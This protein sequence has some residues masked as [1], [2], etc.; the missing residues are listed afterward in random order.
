MSN[1][2]NSLPAALLLL[3][4]GLTAGA[5][6]TT[7]TSTV[8]VLYGC[9][10]PKN[11]NLTRISNTAPTCPRNATLIT[12][13][14][15][16]EKGET[17]LRGEQ[18]PIGLTGVMGER[19]PQGLQGEPGLQGLIGEQ[20]PKGDQGIQGIKGDTGDQG[21]T[22]PAGL[23]GVPGPSDLFLFSGNPNY[24][25]SMSSPLASMTLPP[26]SYLVEAKLASH[27]Y[28]YWSNLFIS[29]PSGNTWMKSG[30]YWGSSQTSAEATVAFT[31]TNEATV[32]ILCDSN[33]LDGNIWIDHFTAIRVG[34]LHRLSQ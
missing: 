9:L 21:N 11:G 20:G 5:S 6:A 7:P 15:K 28:R 1:I 26:G 13:S 27:F 33:G 18:G 10:T 14:A 12:W 31:L 23:Q 24:Q 22:G 2:K 8:D 3:A 25:C 29:T 4:F 32:S 30:D 17:G 34:E 16:G 19:G